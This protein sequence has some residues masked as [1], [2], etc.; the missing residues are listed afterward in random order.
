MDEFINA[1]LSKDGIIPKEDDW[2]SPL[3]GDWN[4]EFS[5]PSGRRV[6]GEWFFRRVLDG[7]AIEDIYICPSRDTVKTN[8]QPD[9]EYGAAI[10]MYN[11]DKRCYDMTYVNA[12][13]TVRLTVNKNGEKIE[14]VAAKASSEQ[15]ET[16]K[17]VFSEIT[18]NTFHWQ[19]IT[20]LEN[21]KERVNGE[22]H[23]ERLH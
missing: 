15:Q 14:C 10:R 7:G 11:K 9:G 2:F 22:V 16:E 21:G 13:V 5:D 3:L 12:A 4:F 6:K 23:A 19:N 20:V 8:P 1:L 18:E 17:W